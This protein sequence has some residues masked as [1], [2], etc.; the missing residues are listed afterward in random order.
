[1]S[2]ILMILYGAGLG[3]INLSNG[4]FIGLLTG[5]LTFIPYMGT[6]TGFFLSISAAFNHETPIL[7]VLLVFFVIQLIEANILVPKFFAY[8]LG[9]HPVWV[10]F[11]LLAGGTWF[12]F[13][14]VLLAMPTLAIFKVI[15]NFIGK[16][17]G[18]ALMILRNL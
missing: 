3:S 4:F 11:A 16:Y 2:L 5:L 12:G 1:M 14:G 8:R 9:V 13:F 10:L 18:A 17:R 6:I 15:S 7:P